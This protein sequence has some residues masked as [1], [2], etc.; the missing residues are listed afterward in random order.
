MRSNRCSLTTISLLLPFSSWQWKSILH[1]ERWKTSFQE[2]IHSFP[3]KKRYQHQQSC[4]CGQVLQAIRNESLLTLFFQLVFPLILWKWRFF[5]KL[6]IF[7][8]KFEY[9]L[10]QIKSELVKNRSN[11]TRLV[12]LVSSKKTLD[13]KAE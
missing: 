11:I 5:F 4:G 12:L 9:K 1:L 2:L 3:A 7:K 6:T 13:L 10:S 8:K